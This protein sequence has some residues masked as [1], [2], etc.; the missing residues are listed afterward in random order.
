[1]RQKGA[2]YRLHCPGADTVRCIFHQTLKKFVCDLT[3]VH[4]IAIDVCRLQYA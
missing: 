3:S 2:K 4:L 1:M